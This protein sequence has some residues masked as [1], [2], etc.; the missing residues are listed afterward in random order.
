MSEYIQYIIVKLQK[1][2]IIPLSITEFEASPK[3]GGVYKSQILICDP[4]L[5]AVGWSWSN[6]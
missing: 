1:H 5:Q 3:A 6:V 4:P 2:E